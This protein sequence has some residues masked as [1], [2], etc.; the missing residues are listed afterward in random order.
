MK[1]NILYTCPLC[2]SNFWTTEEDNG[3]ATHAV[4]PK[5]GHHIHKA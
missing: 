4:C 2:E 3:W 5:C 1:R